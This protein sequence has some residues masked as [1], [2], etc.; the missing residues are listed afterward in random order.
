[1]ELFINLLIVSPGSILFRINPNFFKKK[2][3][4]PSIHGALALFY[5]LRIPRPDSPAAYSLHRIKALLSS[6]AESSDGECN[7]AELSEKAG[8]FLR[9]QHLRLWLQ[10]VYFM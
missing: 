5:G 8:S 7:P 3:W 4:Q 10:T 9:N 6:P 2:Q 1:M